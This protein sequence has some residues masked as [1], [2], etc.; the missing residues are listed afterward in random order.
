MEAQ[1]M[2]TKGPIVCLPE[3]AQPGLVVPWNSGI[4]YRNQA[5]GTACLQPTLEG[6]FV[7]L[8]DAA[9]Q[10]SL[11]ECFASC[12]RRPPTKDNDGFM[13]ATVRRPEAQARAVE[14]TSEALVP[15]KGDVMSISSISNSA[16]PLAS[17]GVGSTGSCPSGGASTTASASA[18]LDGGDGTDSTQLS[19]P[20][21]LLSQLQSLEASDPSKAKAA[22]TQL[23]TDI[24]SQAQQVGGDQAQHMNDFADKLD[25]AAS[26][27]DLS[28]LQPPQGQGP[29]GGAQGAGQAG[30]HHHHHHHKAA[31]SSSSTSSDATSDASSSVDGTNAS[32]TSAGRKAAHAYQSNMPS[33]TDMLNQILSQLNASGASSN[34]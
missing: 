13:C 6:F 8:G 20:A 30:G 18:L 28:V 11:D 15:A 34:G 1:D 2:E 4:R 17:Y 5:G 31:S 14:V 27:G 32:D 22:M 21:Q 3:L 16:N 25:Q 10:S 29:P 19:G 7:P 24:R 26:T 33:P 23:A 9:L 12:L